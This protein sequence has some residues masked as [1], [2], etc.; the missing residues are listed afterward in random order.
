MGAPEV[1]TDPM[2]MEQSDI[3]VGL[4]DRKEWRKDVTKESLAKEISEAVGDPRHLR[5]LVHQRHG[6]HRHDP[7]QD[8]PRLLWLPEGVVREVHPPITTPR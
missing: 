8:D 7:A 1:A 3:Y 5:P 2:G 6:G 4:K